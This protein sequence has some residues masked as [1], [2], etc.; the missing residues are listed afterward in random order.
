MRVIHIARKPLEGTNAANALKHWTGGLNIDRSRIGTEE[1]LDGGAYA[2][3]PTPR[4]G[5]DLWTQDRKGDTNCMRRGGA[6]DYVRPPGRWPANLILEHKPGCK[7]V[8]TRKVEGHVIRRYDGDKANRA[9]GFY[10]TNEDNRGQDQ[11]A[12]APEQ[13]PDTFEDMYECVPDC[14]CVLLDVQS[15]DRSSPWIG[16]TGTG[17]KGGMMFGG[18][19]ANEEDLPKPE[20]RDAGGASRFFKQVGGGPI[21]LP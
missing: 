6:G 9:Y 11:Q 4:A 14:P 15:G 12:T 18:R 16:N 5:K 20:Y 19:S 8:G 17:R 3:N 2:K 1:S 13:Q 10:I 21:D 7:K